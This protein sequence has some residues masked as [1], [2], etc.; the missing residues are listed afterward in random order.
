MSNAQIRKEL[1]KLANNHPELRQHLVP[2][3]KTGG[4]AQE[5]ADLLKKKDLPLD[6]SD[7]LRSFMSHLFRR[8]LARTT[9][10][11]KMSAVKSFYRF[12]VRQ[13]LMSTNPGDG[14]PTP[15]TS[16]TTPRFLSL[17][18]ITSLLDSAAGDEISDLRDLA[19]WELLYSSGLRVSE[20]AG[21]KTKD[22]DPEGRLVRVRPD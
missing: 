16:R 14:I 17:E 6:S 11:R 7:S 5:F 15:R 3:L 20:L 18:E 2:I 10:A 8:G 13:G 22:W 1:I 21:L 9:M 19:I 4:E 12:M